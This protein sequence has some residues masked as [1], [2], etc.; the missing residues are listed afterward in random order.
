MESSDMVEEINLNELFHYYISKLFVIIL[1]AFIGLGLGVF[2]SAIIQ[3]PLYSSYTT[4]LLKDSGN[5]ATLLKTYGELIKSKNVLNKVN[6]NL[7]LNYNADDL[8]G[9]ISVESLNGTEIIKITVNNSKP[10]D[11]AKL[12]NEIASVFNSEIG[13]Y[14][15]NVK[16]SMIVDKAEVSTSPYNVHLMKQ[17]I[18]GTFIG[19]I[20]GIVVVFIKFYF[21]TTVKSSEEVE[22][23]LNLPVIGIIPLVGGR[24]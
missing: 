1:F 13:S 23:K 15:S 18:I 24:K 20:I 7:G 6:S 19:G 14:Y 17:I 10:E 5:N 12:A 8:K 3:K 16:S 21:D 11:A 4:I 2:Y 9:M 22:S